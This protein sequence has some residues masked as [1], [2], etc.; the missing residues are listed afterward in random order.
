MPDWS[1]YNGFASHRLLREAAGSLLEQF[2]VT[3]KVGFF[4]DRH[5]LDPDRLRTAIQQAGA[6]LG[7]APDTVLIH[8]PERSPAAFVPACLALGWMKAEGLL[9]SWGVA[10][11]DPR[12]LLHRTYTGPV[13][14]VLMLRAGL[15]VPTAVLEAGEHLIA[16]MAPVQVHGMAPFG[17]STADPLWSALDLSP[18]LAPG[19]RSDTIAAAFAAAFHLP[20][21]TQIA[22]GTSRTDHLAHLA[23]A[24]LL[25][26][27]TQAIAR[28][29]DLLHRKAT[30]GLIT[31]EPTR[32][33]T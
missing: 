17:H 7:R 13:P 5:D 2:T 25:D 28:Y 21:V 20:P 30:V 12:P 19:Q 1:N 8:N 26:V 22:V 23:Q 10:T 33:L 14:D 9:G 4:P 18:L 6:D 24:R 27:D 16:A 31:P 32:S 15:T 11:W 29:R 3:T